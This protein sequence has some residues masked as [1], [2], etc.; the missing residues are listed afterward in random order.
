M[1]KLTAE[2][3]EARVEDFPE[4]TLSG[5][6]L[7]RTVSFETFPQAIAFVNKVAE[8]AE[9][10]GHHPDIM[11]RYNK[12]TLSLTTHDAGGLTDLDFSFAQRA[13]DL[14]GAA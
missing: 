12:V 14:V 5:D 1:E 13:E 8:V 3:I 2:D 7:Q 4:W 9:Q 10:T 11:I 6:A